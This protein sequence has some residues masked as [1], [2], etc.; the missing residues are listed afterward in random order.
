MEY[1][2]SSC[3]VSVAVQASPPSEPEA[4]H[5]MH[6]S[7]PTGSTRIRPY[8]R[9]GVTNAVEDL[10]TRVDLL[11]DAISG[12]KKERQSIKD[13]LETRKK[14]AG[15]KTDPPSAS[16]PSVSADSRVPPVPHPPPRH[17]LPPEPSSPQPPP[18]EPHRHFQYILRVEHECIR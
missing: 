10:R 13:T 1:K 18:N 3:F 16:P 17:Q 4:V 15:T 14:L 9:G 8:P 7:S 2:D 6:H 12:F 11:S 5:S